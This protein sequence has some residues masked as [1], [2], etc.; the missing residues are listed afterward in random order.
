MIRTYCR[1][2]QNELC[3]YTADTDSFDA[4]IQS[5]C[6]AEQAPRALCLVSQQTEEGTG[7]A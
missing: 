7:C 3:I 5:V 4:A 2:A 6:E 1:N